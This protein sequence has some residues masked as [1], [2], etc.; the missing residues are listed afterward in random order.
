MLPLKPA[1]GVFQLD[2]RIPHTLHG[3][4]SAFKS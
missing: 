1:Q 2:R 4:E 3:A